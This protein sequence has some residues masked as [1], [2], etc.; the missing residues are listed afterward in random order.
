MNESGFGWGDPHKSP[1][2][3]EKGKLPV[4]YMEASGAEP[5]VSSLY[6]ARSHTSIVKFPGMSVT[7]VN[8]DLL[9]NL[10]AFIGS[11]QVGR[12]F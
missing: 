11:A 3:I 12:N 2:D 5:C 4:H 9:S 6:E 1:L 10:A 8:M 7:F